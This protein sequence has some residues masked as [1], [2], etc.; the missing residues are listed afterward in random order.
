MLNLGANSSYVG[1]R[2]GHF[3][4]LSQSPSNLT[5]DDVRV[6]FPYAEAWSLLLVSD[7]GDR[8]LA[9]NL[10][11]DKVSV[12]RKGLKEV[13][14][15][16]AFADMKGDCGKIVPVGRSCI[17]V[18]KECPAGTL[19]EMHRWV[20]MWSVREIGKQV[21]CRVPPEKSSWY[22]ED[23]DCAASFV[24]ERVK[25]EEITIAYFSKVKEG[26]LKFAKDVEL[27]IPTQ[28]LKLCS[29]M[30]LTYVGAI[31]CTRT[32]L[33]KETRDEI[34]IIWT[35]KVR[36]GMTVHKLKKPIRGI[37]H[38]NVFWCRGNKDDIYLF[39][40]RWIKM[41]R[42]NIKTN[43]VFPTVDLVMP[44]NWKCMAACLNGVDGD[45]IVVATECDD[46]LR[47][48]PF[49]GEGKRV[50]KKI[51]L[52]KLSPVGFAKHG[53]LIVADEMD[54][55]AVIDLDGLLRCRILG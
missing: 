32:V 7:V 55:H 23:I 54:H 44:H 6:P 29:F 37:R 36:G 5:S 17:Y 52:E 14:M 49:T 43:K 10:R 53:D 4:E 18:L 27:P 33:G 24:A 30:T 19:I 16:K 51:A 42:V 48:T 41:T 13:D 34:E 50:G 47:I 40:R 35:A 1:Q 12:M 9:W 3:L 26:T 21:I 8:V 31:V 25:V 15:T 2:D 28:V 39:D 11:D 45:V 20:G 46:K 38:E 22:T